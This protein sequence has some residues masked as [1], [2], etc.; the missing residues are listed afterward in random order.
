MEPHILSALLPSVEHCIQIGDHQQL[1]PRIK[2]FKLSLESS[3]GHLYK[4]D[5]SQ[6]ERLSDRELGSS[7]LPVAQLNVQR[8]MRPEI[9]TLIRETIY[10]R[11][12]D[13]DSTFALP[14]VV[15]MRKNVFWLD[16]NHF[17]ESANPDVHNK[18]HSNAWEIEMVHALVRHIVRQ[19]I[20]NSTDIA[21]LTPYGGQLVKLRVKMRDDFEIVLSDRDEDTL[22]EEGLHESSMTPD[23]DADAGTVAGSWPL[24]KKK[25]SELLRIATVDNF[26]G[27]EAKIV[28]ISLV[29][30]NKERKIGFLKTTNR[31]NV[32]L[33]RAQHGMYL[34]GNAETYFNQPMWKHVQAM[35]RGTDSVGT[36]LGLCCRRHPD[37]ELSVT[38]PEDFAI[39]SPEGGCQLACDRRLDCGHR[40]QARCHSDSMHKIFQC[41]QS[42]ER[43]HSRCGHACQKQTCGEDCGQCVAPLPTVQLMC[44]HLKDDVPCYMT[45]RVADIKCILPVQKQIPAC[46]HTV[47]ISCFQDVASSS[48]HCPFPC[49]IQLEC[50]HTCPGSCGRCKN[51]DAE[52]E[53]VKK[54]VNCTVVCGRR[55]GTCNHTCG[56]ACHAGQDCGLCTSSCEV[57]LRTSCAC[58]LCSLFLLAEMLLT[59]ERFGVRT[60]TANNV[61]MK[62]VRLVLRDV[63]GHASIG[64]PVTCHAPPHAIASPATSAAQTNLTAD[65]NALACAVRSAPRLTVKNARIG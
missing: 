28:I 61:A 1:R 5:R 25:M 52:Q 27:E 23:N 55:F 32:L 42:C 20:Y 34:I 9:S 26:Q 44:G 22:A 51:I 33:S 48:F 54:H 35:L 16:H 45:Q 40:C 50:G 2:D 60:P 6:F 11:L 43:L 56:K 30:S 13:H 65:T 19:G 64:V 17:E 36:S 47:E 62:P 29:R 58:P 21:V 10:P 39:L 46:K 49:Q 3:Q 12:L 7:T 24:Q 15:G 14:N 38:K 37:T 31:I 18:S 59:L 8:R 57:S 63:L 4:L 41:P 53:P